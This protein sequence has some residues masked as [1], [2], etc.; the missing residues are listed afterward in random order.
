MAANERP[1]R[2]AVIDDDTDFL[3]LMEEVL[4]EQGYD[5]DLMR[6]VEDAHERIRASQPDVVVCDIVVRLEERGW[7]VVELLTLDPRTSHIPLIVCS[8]AVSALEERRAVLEAQGI[9]LLP[10]PFDLSRLLSAVESA[11]R[12]NEHR[13]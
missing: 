2:V 9:Q 10:K 1:V 12:T 7:Q 11:T 8:A 3:S 13:M 6:T 5:V 4:G